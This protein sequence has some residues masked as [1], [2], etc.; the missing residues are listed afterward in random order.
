MFRVGGSG[1]KILT[2]LGCLGFSAQHSTLSPF[3]ARR[4]EPEL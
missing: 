3:A 2:A 4:E 1:H